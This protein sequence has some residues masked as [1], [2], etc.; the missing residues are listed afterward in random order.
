MN[1]LNFIER[2]Q[3]E[4]DCLEYFKAMREKSGVICKKCG[5]N[6]H[7]WL[8]GKNW[9]ECKQCGNQISIKSGTLMENSKLPIKYW[10]ITMHIL[11]SSKKTFSASELQKQL[12]YPEYKPVCE[13][14]YKLCLVLDNR[15]DE[16]KFDRILFACAKNQILDTENFHNKKKSK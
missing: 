2:F 7:N 8:S 11:T 16:Y 13:M 6:K 10:F 9:F 5:H 3:D 4:N 12:G 15:V 14:L 1:L